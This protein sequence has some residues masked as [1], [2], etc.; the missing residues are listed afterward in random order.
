MPDDTG[1]KKDGLLVGAS[2]RAS[3]ASLFAVGERPTVPWVTGGQMR[4]LREPA[5]QVALFI[6]M[7][8]RTLRERAEH[9][10]DLALGER[11][12]EIA[13]ALL[14]VAECYATLAK[15]FEDSQEARNRLLRP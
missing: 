15:E 2:Y 7:D 9:Y 6:W 5:R 12:A 3:T 14:E 11:N 1:V 13:K 10:R 8:T 4:A